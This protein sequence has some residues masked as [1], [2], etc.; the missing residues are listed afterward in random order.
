MATPEER[1]RRR[2]GLD[3]L[4]GLAVVLMIEQHLGIWL[5]H[6]PRSGE[7]L[8]DFP[9]LVGFNALGGGAAPLF[10]T[11]A[12][13]GAALMVGRG[14]AAVDALLVR[15][16]VVLASFGVVLNLL[17]PSWFSWGSWY[18]LHLMGFA[19]ALT[20]LWRRLTDQGLLLACALVFVATVAAQTELATPP[21]LT[22]ERMRDV[23]LPGGPLR[24]ALA[25]GQ[26]PILP[27][28]AF[29]LAGFLGGRWLHRG[30]DRRIAALGVG[31]LAFGGL[32]HLVYRVG[33]L[34]VPAD[35][36]QRAFGLSLGFYPCSVAMA[37]LLLGGALLLVAASAWVDDRVELGPLHPLVTLGRCSLTLLMVHIPVFRDLSR[38]PWFDWWRSLDAN[39]ALAVIAVVLLVATVLSRAWARVDYRY[40]AEWALRRIAG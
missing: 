37:S 24:L 25:E 30:R 34:P 12:G 26:F 39:Q 32:G 33:F 31:L 28:L 2:M 27:W 18:V 6:G 40:G 14:R 19:M 10:V 17:A 16:G 15:R 9:L 8:G 5:W 4:R 3:A 20:P 29:F 7:S 21:V 38:L 36:G 1:T 35:I 23:S 22:N 11:L 13:V